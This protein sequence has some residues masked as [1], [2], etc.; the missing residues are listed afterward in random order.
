MGCCF[1][2]EVYVADVLGC[3][4]LKGMISSITSPFFYA[5]D[6][7]H[8]QPPVKMHGGHQLGLPDDQPF[9]L[10]LCGGPVVKAT[11]R[12]VCFIHPALVLLRIFLCW[13]L[14]KGLKGFI[15]LGLLKPILAGHVDFSSPV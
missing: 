14:L 12:S 13:P 1:L 8:C 7:L 11:R 3:F 6:G 15:F 10:V 4:Q 5:L 9:I 2:Q